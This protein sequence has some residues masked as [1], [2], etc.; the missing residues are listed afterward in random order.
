MNLKR[1]PPRTFRELSLLVIPAVLCFACNAVCW[2]ADAASLLLEN[3]QLRLEIEPV[4]GT[5][6]RMVD[7]PTGIELAAQPGLAGNYTLRIVLPDKQEAVITG[8]DQKLSRV[9]EEG[10]KRTLCWDGPLTDGAG[11]PYDIPVRMEVTADGASLTF[12]L[13]LDNRTPYKVR[14]ACYPF[15]GGFARFA[16]AGE[17]PD[18]NVWAP[19]SS[20]WVK[21]IE[22]PFGGASFGYPGHLN[23]S[24]VCI[25]NAQR[26][27]TLY[28]SSQDSMARYK[29]YQL[30]EQSGESGKDV[31]SYVQHLP[32]TPPGGSFTGSPI[33]YRFMDG[34]WTSAGRVYR[35][36]FKKTFG[37][38]EPDRCWIRKQSFFMMTMFMMPEG[39]IEYRFTDIPRWGK[40]AKDHGVN[41]VMI[42]GWQMGGHDNGY[43]LYV[44]DPRLGTLEELREGIRRL[45]EMGLK[46][47]FF[48]N[49]QPM[50]VEMDWYKKELKRYL[51]MREDGNATW[52]AGWPMGTLY[53]RM[54]HPKLMSW[55][56]LGFPEFRKIIA[57]Q[58]RKLAEIGA[59]G[60][61]VDKMF[62]AAISYN[63]NTPM[64][65]DTS[66]WEGAIELTRQIMDECRRIN[67]NWAMSFECN[68]DRM[69]QFT[70][71]T[72]WVGNMAVVRSIFP[73]N[74]ET[75]AIT[76]AYD[77]L[78]VNNAVR[79]RHTVQVAMMNFSRGLDWAPAAGL[80]D[81]IKEVKG[82][83]DRLMD[84]A[85]LGE[86]LGHEGAALREPL[87]AG[88]E[89]NV[90]RN[91]R[92]G[93]RVCILTNSRMASAKQVIKGFGG[94]T[95]GKARVH[96]PYRKPVVVKLPAA[97]DIPGERIV[98]V[99]EL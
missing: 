23:M 58:F 61:H 20:P 17:A 28:W 85:Y 26:N 60:V 95:T 14:E 29:V 90:L 65:P 8:K 84:T 83:Q 30:A 80:A 72:W 5:I 79:N 1:L 64:T 42:S 51:E 96:T 40:A 98:F 86:V 76:Q 56:D 15:I 97:V 54:G 34:D 92:T 22:L 37:L 93:K 88:V 55:A 43:P 75:L 73:E 47:Y 9:E 63:P 31:V 16:P 3:E 87:P 38:M 89:Y 69:L 50:M 99:E 53:G 57:D 45:H 46:V 94:S 2:A 70:D 62:P 4:H 35:E 68:W 48:V 44:P 10:S 11:A 6:S 41:A 77:Y 78:G 39:S 33:F 7:K 52:L 12:R 59:D 21:K 18:A 67:P 36:W 91:T 49:Y 13:R 71:A 25:R 27:R 19:T 66:T 82:I 24:F 74:V 81:Y 32:F